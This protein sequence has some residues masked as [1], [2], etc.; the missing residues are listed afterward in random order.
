MIRHYLLPVLL[1]V[2]ATALV[3]CL[4]IIVET[5][6]HGDLFSGITLF[7]AA[8]FPFSAL[9]LLALMPIVEMVRLRAWAIAGKASIVLCAGGLLGA[10]LLA[11]FSSIL[12]AFCGA[13]SASIWLCLNWGHLQ[14]PSITS[15]IRGPR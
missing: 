15:T 13:L 14:S 2:G 1:T 4:T 3:L 12:G 11:W 8:V 5:G 6:I 7:A 9:G 10:A